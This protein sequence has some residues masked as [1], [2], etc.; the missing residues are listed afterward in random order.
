MFN[1]SLRKKMSWGNSNWTRKRKLCMIKIFWRLVR[2]KHRV[3]ISLMAIDQYDQCRKMAMSI[4][5]YLQS[6]EKPHEHS[7]KTLHRSWKDNQ[8]VRLNK[9]NLHTSSWQEVV[10]RNHVLHGFC[11]WKQRDGYWVAWTMQAKREE[12]RR[13]AI[14]GAFQPL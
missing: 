9:I 7:N 14:Y 8:R 10:M 13:L 2:K 11:K 6:E 3:E 4:K 12:E 5:S 1:N